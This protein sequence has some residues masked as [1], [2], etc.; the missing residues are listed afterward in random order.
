M[1]V[2][3]VGYISGNTA[4]CAVLLFGPAGADFDLAGSSIGAVTDD[5]MIAKLVHALLLDVGLVE[6]DGTSGS[7]SAVMYDDVVPAFGE[8]GHAPRSAAGGGGPVG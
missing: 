6:S 5:E 3:F 4:V 7:G 1:V 2:V 8:T